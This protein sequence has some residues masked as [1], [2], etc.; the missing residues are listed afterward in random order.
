[1]SICL[2]AARDRVKQAEAV[3]GVWLESPRDDYECS[4]ISSVI[5]LLEGVEEAINEADIKLNSLK[6]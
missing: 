6:K 4:L 2:L 5:T 3:L 1:M